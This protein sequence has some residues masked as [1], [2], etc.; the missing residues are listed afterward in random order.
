[1]YSLRKHLL[2]TLITLQAHAFS[3]QENQPRGTVVGTVT[4]TDNNGRYHWAGRI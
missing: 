2:I 4:I 1:M 3:V